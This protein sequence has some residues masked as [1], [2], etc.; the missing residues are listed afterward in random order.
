MQDRG[1]NDSVDQLTE[2]E[3]KLRMQFEE[4]QNPNTG[5]AQPYTYH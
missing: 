5:I 4:F 3:R 1:D 2:A